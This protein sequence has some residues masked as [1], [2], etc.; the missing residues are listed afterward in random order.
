MRCPFCL[1][2]DRPMTREHVFAHWLVR[3][4]HGGRL[5]PSASTRGEAN[6]APLRIARVVTSVCA[7]C[8]AG[9]M[10]SLEVAFRRVLFARR[11]SGPIP[12][13]D[14]VILARWLTKTAVLLTDAQGASLEIDR[15]RLVTGMPEGIDVLLARRRRPPQRLDFALDTDGSRTRSVAI[16]VDDVVAHVASSGVLGGRHGT[17]IFPLR[18]YALRWETLPVIAPGALRT[19][20]GAGM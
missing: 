6:V 9:W 20:Y 12:A 8:N 16:L 11:R 1:R 19:G 7:D 2:A 5:V 17:R 13:A 4:V 18:T 15:A 14:R 10:S 3:H